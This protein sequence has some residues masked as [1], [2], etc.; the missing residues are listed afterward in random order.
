MFVRR[1][2]IKEKETAAVLKFVERINFFTIPRRNNKK[3]R[4]WEGELKNH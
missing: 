1:F 4:D 3:V 2:N